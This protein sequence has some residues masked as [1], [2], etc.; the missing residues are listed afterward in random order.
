M[1]IPFI[2]L[3]LL[4][5]SCVQ[6][7]P[8]A[9]E[10]VT[11]GKMVTI[12]VTVPESGD[13]KVAFTPESGK[14]ALSWETTDCIRVISGSDSQ[15]YTI[16]N[17]I[18]DHEAEFTGYAVSGS[19]FD[20]ICPG[21]YASVTEAEE[22]TTSP[23]QTGNGSTS[24]L[25][26]KA[27]LSGVNTYEDIAFTSTWA[28]EHGGS[29]KNGAVV[30]LEAT[31]PSGVTT[32][33]KAA[34]RL[35]GNDYSLP[36]SGVDVS[37]DGQVLTAYMSLPWQDIAIPDGST[38]AVYAMA[39][40]NEVYS[41]VL[42]ITGDKTIK[43]G[44]TNS[45]TN[46]DLALADFV[47]GDG[48]EQNP[49]L[50][51]N[52]RQLEN[53]MNLY[54][55]ATDPTDQDSFKYW[56]KLIEDVDASGIA[57]KPLNITG[58]FY[59]A[60]DF[61][62]QGHTITGLKPTGTYASFAGVLN[63][64]ISNVTFD[65]A[66]ITPGSNTKCGVVAGFVGT[67]FGSPLITIPATC[68]SVTV[69]NSTVN[70]TSTYAGGFAGHVKTSGAIKDCHVIDT[71][72]SGTGG[73]GGFAG[74]ADLGGYEVP[75]V[76]SDCSV[77]GVTVTQNNA[78][79][80]ITEVP[81]GGFIGTTGQAYTFRD[82]TVSNTSVTAT[83][84]MIA[85]IGGFIGSTTYAGA[86]FQ[87]CHV[88]DDVTITAKST[89]VGGFVGYAG[90][91][92]IYKKCTSDAAVTNASNYTGGFVGYAIGAASFTDCDATG[93]ISANRFTGGFVGVAENASFTDCSYRQGTITIN[94][95]STNARIGGFV[96]SAL[97]GI[98]FQGCD[99]H[100][101]VIT[102]TKAGRVGGFAGQLG[103]SSGGGNNITTKSCYVSNTAVSG[104]INTGGFSGVQYETTNMCYVSGGSV[105][106]N[107]NNC[108]GFTGFIQ[109]GNISH[110]YTTA[111]VTGGSSYTAVAGFAGAAYTTDISYCYTS[112]SVSSNGSTDA[113]AFVG[114][115]LKQGDYVANVSK[116][117]AWNASLPFV[118]KNEVG[119]TFTDCYAGTEGSVSAKATA[120]TWPTTVWN[121]DDTLP[122]LLA[123]PSRINAIFVG[124]SITW[125]WARVS[126]TEAK[127]KILVPI[128]PLPSY[129]TVSGDNVTTRFHPGF[130][131]GNG[132]VDKGISGQN[133]TQ[134]LERFERD[135]VDQN[136]VVVVIMG[137]TND[138]AQGVSK[139][140]IVANIASMAEMAD[141]NGI[142]VVLC[143]VTPNNDSYSR[144]NDP[145]TKGAHIIT[146]NGMLQDYANSKG[147]AWCDYWS[148]LVG[149]DGFAM[150]EQ[151][152]LYDRLHPSPAGY[153]VMEAII[154][155]IIDGL[156]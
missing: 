105:T 65:G 45:F 21:T 26:Y 38:V 57:W 36:L 13:T 15:V 47:D 119:A 136:P 20:I 32:L 93:N 80:S 9:Q 128:D 24:H 30:K 154:K 69:K 111:S 76:F 87:N 53:M 67:T 120:Q 71:Q 104:A 61:D 130:F 139:A 113:G 48:S 99:V 25:V 44:S 148:A 50:I 146:L 2:A 18:S 73:L 114:Q 64:K 103:N 12:R 96:G 56:F 14:L 7:Q 109:N 89:Y 124:D 144:L 115:C 75:A 41:A 118:A 3:T 123:S 132:Y 77:E 131:A 39:T 90:V 8:L 129:M 55:N 22:D 107:G 97:S 84:G 108:G 37:A 29:F 68:E 34:I 112:G 49:Y 10:E 153:D 23:T 85:D 6:E 138:L 95:N 92:D 145:K 19:S 63:G 110:C 62:G 51:A 28:G 86:N 11:G 17:I 40:D 70:G 74:M 134:M 137:G 151:Y 88:S 156:L 149:S 122:V 142:K 1:K 152:W 46:V 27:L 143:T 16:S 59:K 106:A 78:A 101:A 72:I 54:K 4:L 102:G 125:Q 58:N 82:C 52:A 60:I 66:T 81:T 140:D 141:G 116:C 98:T 127:S 83:S 5:G 94:A 31:L 147:F 133:T 135:V 150:D 126:R 42:P 91:P 43:C 117:I 100:Y 35:G 121:L 33:K 155:P 79:T